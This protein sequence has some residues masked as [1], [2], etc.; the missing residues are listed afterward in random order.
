MHCLCARLTRTVRIHRGPDDTGA[1]V[2]EAAGVA[3]AHRCLA[4][5]DLTPAG[6]QPMIS[7]CGCYVLMFRSWL[8][9]IAYSKHNGE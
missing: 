8:D 4:I 9:D 6:A 5:L 1:W 2:D 7:V 3:L